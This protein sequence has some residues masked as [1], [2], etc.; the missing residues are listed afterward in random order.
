[1]KRVELGESGLFAKRLSW[2]SLAPQ[3]LLG[4]STALP[5]SIDAPW[6]QTLSRLIAAANAAPVPTQSGRQGREDKFGS[7]FTPLIDVARAHLLSRLHEM[8]L[9]EHTTDQALLGF[10]LHLHD[11]LAKLATPTLTREYQIFKA[12]RHPLARLSYRASDQQS[13]DDFVRAAHS[14]IETFLGDYPVLAR[15]LS[16]AV[17]R[18]T[19]NSVTVIHRFAVDRSKIAGFFNQ[20]QPVGRLTGVTAGLSDF[21]RRNQ[22][23]CRLECES[24][25]RV[26]YKPRDTRLEEAFGKFLRWLNQHD[27]PIRLRAPAVLPRHDYGWTEHIPSQPRK[28]TTTLLRRYGA[29]LFVLYLLDGTDAHCENII[30]CGDEP[31]L[32]DAETL[33]SPRASTDFEVFDRN[34]ARIIYWESVLKCGFLPEWTV[35]ADGHAYDM[36]VFSQEP[37]FESES[38]SEVQASRDVQVRAVI[39]GFEALYQFVLDKQGEV[40]AENGPLE[41]FRQLPVRFIFRPT[42]NY[43]TLLERCCHPEFLQR[44]SVRS[45]EFEVLARTFR[46]YRKRPRLWNVLKVELSELEDLDIPFFQTTTS[47]DGLPT[48]HGR[49]ARLFEQTGYDHVHKNVEKLSSADLGF[50]TQIIQGTFDAFSATEAHRSQDNACD[51][52][53]IENGQPMS[54]QAMVEN[55]E[56]IGNLIIRHA[57]RGEDGQLTWLGLAP[58]PGTDRHRLQPLNFDLYSG[59]SGVA[60]FLA[61]LSTTTGRSEYAEYSLGAMRWLRDC[62]GSDLAARQFIKQMKLG[63]GDGVGGV[64]YALVHIASLLQLE[65]ELDVANSMVCHVAPA[66]LPTQGDGGFGILSGVA[67]A[68]LGLLTL[69]ETTGETLPLTRAEEFSKILC[70]NAECGESGCRTWKDPVAHRPLTGFAHGAAGIGYTLLR[71]YECTRKESYLVFGTDALRYEELVFCEDVNNWPDFRVFPD[72]KPIDPM[73]AW[74]HGAPGIGM[75]RAAML[76][77]LDSQIIRRDIDIAIRSIIKR[78]LG[79]ADYLCCGN[80]G[81]LLILDGLPRQVSRPE[82]T[83]WARRQAARL[84]SAASTSGY[85]LPSRVRGGH[86][87]GL[88]Q[89]LSGIGYGF[90][91][92]AAQGRLPAVLLFR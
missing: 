54:D 60:L 31:V 85:R 83:E 62:L 38:D 27:S 18:W 64:F 15:L 12:L 88:F 41:F 71:M 69:H 35:A 65:K 78:G 25:F 76:S 5:T 40:L 74:C 19:E 39:Q 26:I 70:E 75:A 68:I 21:H 14:R 28:S 23:V 13:E 77:V 72:K 92:M 45:I 17:D 33:F 44:G 20:G 22:T 84:A 43:A 79:N 73:V 8:A 51:T 55:A 29:L 6:L 16:A 1:M 24:G 90:L 10:E 11:V 56:E 36:S 48:S 32:V 63:I 89:G 37:A 46:T 9:T 2:D 50:Q 34:L 47:D 53:G 3:D 42:S 67:G 59:A 87:P 86:N 81:R 80:M 7:F 82:L 30:V 66:D 58:L 91:E 49:I 57:I 52:P 61:A 4:R